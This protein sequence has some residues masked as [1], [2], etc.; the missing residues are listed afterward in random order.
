M[1]PRKP[2]A[3]D[4]FDDESSDEELDAFDN[5]PYSPIAFHAAASLTG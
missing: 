5:P 1:R 2:D 3:D 4:P